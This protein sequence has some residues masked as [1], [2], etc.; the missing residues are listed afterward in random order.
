[1]NR[2]KFLV[3]LFGSYLSFFAFNKSDFFIAKAD[4]LEEEIINQKN[5]KT[6]NFFAL[7]NSFTEY[8]PKTNKCTF[9]Y[10]LNLNNKN[11]V[12][13]YSGDS[14]EF[15]IDLDIGIYV[16]SDLKK[17]YGI[18]YVTSN[19][20][21]FNKK[22]NLVIVPNYTYH[23]YNLYTKI[24]NKYVNFYNKFDN[25]SLSTPVF[26][27][28]WY[29]SPFSNPINFLKK[30]SINFDLIL[31]S[32]IDFL[33]SYKNLK[34][35]KNIIIYGHDEYW[36]PY[37]RNTIDKTIYNGSNLINLSGNTCWWALKLNK[38]KKIINR[39][40]FSYFF[41]KENNFKNEEYLLGNSFRWGGYP[42]NTLNSMKLKKLK[43]TRENVIDQ[44]TKENLYKFKNFEEL[45]EISSFPLII[46]E[47][48]FFLK[49]LN[50]K[51]GEIIKSKYPIL[52]IEVDGLPLKEDNSIDENI[53]NNFL[54]K[55]Y[56]IACCAYT[57][58]GLIRKTG[59]M[60]KS[61]F[62]KGKVFSISSIGWIRNLTKNDLVDKI[63]LNVLNGI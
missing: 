24:N 2:R 12:Y 22:D 47:K 29:H 54:P 39:K 32:E 15:T 45:Q 31:Q 57:Y 36:T 6:N 58:R 1:M 9:F 48:S 16:I 55:N 25:I 4:A 60:I 18:L 49:N 52:D 8:N 50:L 28:V 20:N 40:D 30:N 53:T 17:N 5:K 63:T 42:L 62:G 61:D 33:Y 37:I 38:E 7:I 59:F 27:G 14:K 13:S 26:D 44:I 51:K 35:Y 43:L 34:S 46:N 23:A 56:D 11:N 19:L 21:K 3:N 41:N 10:N